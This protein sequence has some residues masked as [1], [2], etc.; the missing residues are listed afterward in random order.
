MEKSFKMELIPLFPSL[1]VVSTLDSIVQELREVETYKYHTVSLSGGS[2]TENYKVLEKF[3]D[4]KKVILESFHKFTKEVLG[5]N[6]N[7]A[8]STS[9][10]TKHRQHESSDLHNHKNCYY[11]AVLYLDDIEEGGTLCFNSLG[12]ERSSY[13]IERSSTPN[14]F[15]TDSFFIQP[16]K[17]TIVF[18]P[19]Y[20]MHK[21]MP[22][23]GKKDRHSIALNFV[24]VGSYGE[25]DSTSTGA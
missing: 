7:F 13:L 11:S 8:I 23:E 6:T 19:S 16:Q 9:W 5:Y 15:N 20:L 1:V 2:S 12:L 10:G 4:S 17:N 25:L 18:F 21:V 22:Y 24:P 14:P 3:P